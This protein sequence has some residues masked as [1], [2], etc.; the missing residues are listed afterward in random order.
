[1]TQKWLG[2]LRTL[3]DQEDDTYTLLKNFILVATGYTKRAAA[4]LLF[5]AS[6]KDSAGKMFIGGAFG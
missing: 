2:I 4:R 5:N 3:P 1:M 6:A